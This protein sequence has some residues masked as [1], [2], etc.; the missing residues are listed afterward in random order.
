MT[1]FLAMSSL[2][3]VSFFFLPSAFSTNSGEEINRHAKHEV[4]AK[5]IR[6]TVERNHNRRNN[7]EVPVLT[8]IRQSPRIWCKRSKDSKFN[9]HWISSVMSTSKFSCCCCK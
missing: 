5:G 9:D 8:R 2:W 4:A 3:T 1:V 6:D 7:E